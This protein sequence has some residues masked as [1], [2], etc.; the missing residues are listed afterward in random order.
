MGNI[1]GRDVLVWVVLG[2]IAGAIADAFV[3]GNGNL[4]RRQ[5]TFIHFTT[6]PGEE[7][8]D[9]YLIKP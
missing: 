1:Q 3:P 4:N 2:I 5:E 9:S 7:L 8:V 6:D